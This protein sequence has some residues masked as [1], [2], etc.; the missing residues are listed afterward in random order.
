MAVE[1]ALEDDWVVATQ[2]FFF[3]FTPKLGEMIKFDEHIFSDGLKA[4]TRAGISSK[5]MT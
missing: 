4:P 1:T 5:T 2:I 3:I